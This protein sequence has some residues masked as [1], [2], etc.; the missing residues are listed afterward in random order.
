M[1]SPHSIEPVV[2]EQAE[3]GLARGA[4]AGRATSQV[5]SFRGMTTRNPAIPKPLPRAEPILLQG[6]GYSSRT[7][8]DLRGHVQANDECDAVRGRWAIVP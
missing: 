4:A 7:A 5:A 8:I 3:N 2:K 1:G 6:P